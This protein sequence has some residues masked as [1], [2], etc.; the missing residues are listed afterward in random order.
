[1]D[2]RSENA[3]QCE[4]SEPIQELSALRPLDRRVAPHDDIFAV[5][6][7]DDPDVPRS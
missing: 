1:M 4:R 5:Q 3:S 7:K 2:L 6:R